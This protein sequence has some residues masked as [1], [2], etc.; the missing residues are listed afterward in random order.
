MIP[1]GT[2]EGT[3]ISINL[4]YPTL[5]GIKLEEREIGGRG[6][7]V[8]PDQ[9]GSTGKEQGGKN[10]RVEERQQRNRRGNQTGENLQKESAQHLF[11]TRI[12]TRGADRLTN[13]NNRDDKRVFLLSVRRMPVAVATCQTARCVQCAPTCVHSQ[14]RG[15]RFSC[16]CE[17][18][19]R[20]HRRSA[21]L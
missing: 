15:S 8:L 4:H 6:F 1:Q 3:F 19:C 7:K 17:L 13:S 14:Q 16:D 11:H 12:S 18:V 21:A 20:F 5:T 2:N 10:E 9:P